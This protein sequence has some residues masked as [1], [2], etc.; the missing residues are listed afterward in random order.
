MEGIHYE[1]K[2][3]GKPKGKEFRSW[4][5]N[6]KNLLK[7]GAKFIISDPAYHPALTKYRGELDFIIF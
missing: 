1:S 6:I 7:N 2:T 3:R 4:K 5:K